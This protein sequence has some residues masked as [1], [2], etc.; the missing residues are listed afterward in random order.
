MKFEG[1]SSGSESEVIVD[2]GLLL[3]L[4]ENYFSF[5]ISLVCVKIIYLQD[6][7]LLL[8]SASFQ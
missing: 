8:V 5:N 2:I 7:F 1:L 3:S 4:S 6:T